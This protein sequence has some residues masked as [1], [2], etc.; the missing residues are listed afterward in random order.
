MLATSILHRQA[1]D[2]DASAE[3]AHVPHPHESD[4]GSSSVDVPSKVGAFVH[5]RRHGSSARGE[6]KNVATSVV[7]NGSGEPSGNKTDSKKEPVGGSGLVKVSQSS[8]VFRRTCS[9]LNFYSVKV[10]LAS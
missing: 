6:P 9:C 4:P 7:S 3:R 10:L 2:T 5:R 1:S 8:T